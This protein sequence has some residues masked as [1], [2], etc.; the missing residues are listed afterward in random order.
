ML[1]REAVDVM[2][3]RRPP[4]SA[5]SPRLIRAGSYQAKK[6]ARWFSTGYLASTGL[7]PEEAKSA[8]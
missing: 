6:F 7:A 1:E 3:R 2:E 5:V 4:L 8:C